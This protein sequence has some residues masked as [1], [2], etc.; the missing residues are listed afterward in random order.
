MT[1]YP[2][3]A[4]D[5]AQAAALHA[6]IGLP[7]RAL[8]ALCG[9]PIVR[10][11]QTLDPEAQM[12][13]RLMGAARRPTLQSLSP[14]DARVEYNDAMRLVAG[15]PL[16]LAQVR[17]V[18]VAGA[19]GPLPARLFVPLECAAG[20]H[21]ALLVYFH[22]G[23]WVVGDLDSYDATCRLLARSAGVR[24][25]SVDYRLAPEHRYPA[26]A[27][28]AWAAFAD[29]RAD[30]ARFGADPDRIAVGGDSAGG[31][32]AAVC[33]Q[34]AVATGEPAPAFQL[35]IYPATDSSS[36]ATAS[37]QLFGEGFA[38]T[39]DLMRWF[40]GHY[41]GADEA[42]LALESAASPLLAA[43]LAGLC[44]AHVVT[45]GFDPLRDEGEAYAAR[46]RDAG[47]AVTARRHPGM[48]HSFV[49]T[50]GPGRAAREA[51]VEM[52]GVLRAGLAR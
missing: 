10:D 11:G 15:R 7:P 13:L 12:L 16:P 18:T 51:I 41:F 26:A 2:T 8:R 32:L 46:L 21:S 52:G 4:A 29:V 42:T 31:T 24:V 40:H 44:P 39:A 22:G 43:D 23:G 37:F 14:V 48:I 19:D 5:R 6:A 38:L 36:Q 47:V 35:L 50:P 3:S 33:A 25:L 1:G 20:A 17:D 45:A 27:D 9:S 49:T 30:A 28:D 34:R